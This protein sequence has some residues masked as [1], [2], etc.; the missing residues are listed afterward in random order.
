MTSS[1]EAHI[2]TLPGNRRDGFR[3][4]CGSCDQSFGHLKKRHEHFKRSGHTP[5]E[6]EE[7]TLAFHLNL[8]H[9]TLRCPVCS[10]KSRHVKS[11]RS[12]MKHFACHS[13]IYTLTLVHVC[14]ICTEQMSLDEIHG[15]LLHYQLERIPFTPTNKELNVSAVS[16][17]HESPLY[18]S[19]ITP[20]ESS[21]P[22][23][24]STVSSP[25][26][27]TSPNDYPTKSNAPDTTPSSLPS[28]TPTIADQSPNLLSPV[29]LSPPLLSQPLNN[30][31][32]SS[33][34]TMQSTTSYNLPLTE[35]TFK[36]FPDQ[37]RT[38][39]LL[40]TTVTTLSPTIP[41]LMANIIATPKDHLPPSRQGVLLPPQRPTAADFFSPPPPTHEN[42]PDEDPQHSSLPRPTT[43]INPPPSPIAEDPSTGSFPSTQTTTT[44]HEFRDRY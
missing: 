17:F 14:T 3:F 21:D 32:T 34:S 33:L 31:T 42:I 12:F 44:L 25:E 19:V 8:R 43:S 4:I 28:T 26:P 39:N 40:P 6:I 29:P 15:H 11:P 2:S 38:L 30:S 23:P 37:L 27:S 16:S 20:T 24:T 7:I 18:H 5:K 41:P 1:P 36:T 35:S 13:E 10:Y 22:S 9:Q